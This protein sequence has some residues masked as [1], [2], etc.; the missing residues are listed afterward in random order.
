LRNVGRYAVFINKK[1]DS[2]FFEK[3]SNRRDPSLDHTG[4]M[5]PRFLGVC[6]SQATAKGQHLL[7]AILVFHSAPRKNQKASK[8]LHLRRAPGHKNFD[9]TIEIRP[10][11]DNGRCFDRIH[12]F[13]HGIAPR[14]VSAVCGK[15]TGFRLQPPFGNLHRRP[16]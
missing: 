7:R 16:F 11:N 3:L 4:P 8:E 5:S 12:N 15:A 1:M 6:S 10:H 9:A 2:G 13:T 14:R